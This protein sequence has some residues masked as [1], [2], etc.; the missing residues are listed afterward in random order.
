MSARIIN[1]WYLISPDMFVLHPALSDFGSAIFLILCSFLK[2]NYFSVLFWQVF[3]KNRLSSPNYARLP[4]HPPLLFFYYY[5]GGFTSVHRRFGDERHGIIPIPAPPLSRSNSLT[6]LS[7]SILTPTARVNL[8]CHLQSTRGGA[9]S[10]SSPC[11]NP[12]TAPL[13]RGIKVYFLPFFLSSQYVFLSFFPSPLCIFL[14][15][16]WWKHC[17]VQFKMFIAVVRHMHG[18]THR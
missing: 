8:L 14:Y 4:I 3:R 15:L 11:Q 18:K 2:K 16:L 10:R 12:P 13:F 5:R 9:K 1:I 7:D 17:W 6:K